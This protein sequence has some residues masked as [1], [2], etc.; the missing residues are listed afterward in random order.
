[1]TKTTALFDMHRELGAKLVDFAGWSMPLHYGSQIEEHHCVRKAAGIFD[2][3]HM[4]IIDV[5]GAGSETYF[6]R[7]IAN[8]VAKLKSNGAALYGL[9]LNEEGGIIDDIIVYRQ[10]A[11]FRLISN[12]STRH[13]VVAWLHRHNS[14]GIEI[15]EAKLAMMAIQGPQAIQAFKTVNGGAVPTAAFTAISSGELFVA[16]TGYTGEDGLEIILPEKLAT[17]FWKQMVDG[18]V[19]PIGLGARDSLRLEAGLNLYGLDMTENTSPLVSNLSWTL[20]WEA[21]D[22]NFIGKEALER[23]LEEGASLKLTGLVLEAKG[24]MRAGQTVY[25]GSGNGVVTSGIFSPT[26]GCSI[27]LARLPKEALGSCEIGL[28]GKRA[29][30]RIVRPPFVRHG[31]KI[32]Q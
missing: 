20:C 13:G 6:R 10:R 12:A 30:A 26:L 7:L 29:K 16:R 19:R 15:V 25:T 31:K 3:S 24:V 27:A 5:M 8:D 11:G 23:Q 4:T 1:M 22:R 2:V 21:R 14:E 32:Y 17:E 9:L 28:R 18:G